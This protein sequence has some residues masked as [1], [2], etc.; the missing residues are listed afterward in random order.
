M[1]QFDI[2]KLY[3]LK[4]VFILGTQKLREKQICESN[5]MDRKDM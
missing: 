2:A 3:T 4:K 1:N 5:R